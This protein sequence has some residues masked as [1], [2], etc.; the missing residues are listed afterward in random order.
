MSSINYAKILTNSMRRVVSEVL[1][2]VE[3]D[4]LQ[5][6]HHYYIE[7]YTRHPDAGVP[8]RLIADH[9]K[10]MTIV[11]QHEFHGLAVDDKGFAVRLSFG[12][13]W[14]E[15]YVPLEA[16]IQFADPSTSFGLRF[17]DTKE[18]APVAK[19]DDSPSEPTQLEA[20]DQGTVVSLDRF[21]NRR[22]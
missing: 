15:I 11:L 2:L 8:A 17:P 20:E 21:R 14:E 13:R 7:F 16:I 3:R 1:S 10:S 9:P 22:K 12:N 4:G 5:G 19:S 18:P 6:E